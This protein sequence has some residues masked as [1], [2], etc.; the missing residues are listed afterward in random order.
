MTTKQVLQLEMIEQWFYDQLELMIEEIIKS[1]RNIRTF[2]PEPKNKAD[3]MLS[4]S[5]S[6]PFMAYLVDRA[7]WMGCSPET[8][9]LTTPKQ[10][11]FMGCELTSV[12]NA[13]FVWEIAP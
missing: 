9:S 7:R 12:D 1:R 8:V 10:M 11:S 6:Y 4:I 5:V 2:Y 13:A 3:E